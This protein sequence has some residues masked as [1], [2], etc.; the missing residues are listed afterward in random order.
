MTRSLADAA[1]WAQKST[2]TMALPNTHTPS[3]TEEAISARRVTGRRC[4]SERKQTDVRQ[5]SHSERVE[6]QWRV[7]TEQRVQDLAAGQHAESTEDSRSG[8]ELE[9]ATS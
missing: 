6:E 5:E 9:D 2:S 8:I 1:S 3:A 7:H 4:A